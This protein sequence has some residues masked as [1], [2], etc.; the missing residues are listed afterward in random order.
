MNYSFDQFLLNLF[1]AASNIP[2]LNQFSVLVLIR[3]A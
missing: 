3:F 2:N 1:N